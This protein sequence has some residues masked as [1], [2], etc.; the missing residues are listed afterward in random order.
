MITE[1]NYIKVIFITMLIFTL[2]IYP[3]SYLFNSRVVFLEDL[4]ASWYFWKT[5]EFNLI[6]LISVWI[7]FIGHLFGNFYLI[8]QIQKNKIRK[9]SKYHIKMYYLNTIF[10]ALHFLQT[11][12]TF[13]GLAK[14]LPIWTSQGSVIILLIIMLVMLSPIRGFIVNK[15]IKG[16]LINPLYKFHG[17]L[18]VFAIILTFWYHPIYFTWGHLLG[19]IYIFILMSQFMLVKLKQ[20]MNIKWLSLI[21]TFVFFH[22]ITIAILV[23][24]SRNW[25][26]FAFGFGTIF[27]LTTI[28]GLIK[29]Q[30]LIKILQIIY[31]S[32]YIIYSIVAIFL[33]I[34]KLFDFL[35]IIFIPLI[36]Y[37]FGFILILLLQFRSN[38]K[39]K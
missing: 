39:S 32:I 13:D 24:Q 21:E 16:S 30:K 17:F 22:S 26:I 27:M 18:F 9:F 35:Q 38:Y 25:E 8:W 6:N 20:H 31:F 4:G 2:L 1:K 28:Y 19:F 7:L 37:L 14:Y 34:N 23:Q 33:N 15:K 5:P 12:S 29:N 11:A 3:F 10:I 36:L